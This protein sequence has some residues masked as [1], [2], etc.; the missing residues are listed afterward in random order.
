META[1]PSKTRHGPSARRA[2]LR[3]GASD[4]LGSR[5]SPARRKPTA[6]LLRVQRQDYVRGLRRVSYGEIMA[7]LDIFE[8]LFPDFNARSLDLMTTDTFKIIGDK[9]GFQF[10]GEPYDGPEGLALRGFY[11]TRRGALRRPLVFVNTAHHPIAVTTSFIHEL[12]HHVAT[13]VG[14]GVPHE[15]QCFDSDYPNQLTEPGELLADVMVSM[16]GYPNGVARKI[17]T[18]PWSWGLVARAENLTEAAFAEVRRHLRR[19]YGF[20]LSLKPRED[21]ER[22]LN[23]LTGVIHYAKLR[24]AL[25]AEYDL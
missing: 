2:D 17:F 16:A 6:N 4:L 23:Y 12:T 7:V 15:H 5:R 24:W 13:M 20:K 25:L 11:V 8:D 10:K 21:D 14:R 18:T 3:L 9:L 1:K 22:S 19:S